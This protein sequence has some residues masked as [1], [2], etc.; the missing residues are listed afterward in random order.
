MV[1]KLWAVTI[2]VGK[3]IKCEPNYREVLI[4]SEY[5]LNFMKKKIQFH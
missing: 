1:S 3:Y 2:P 4:I 5:N